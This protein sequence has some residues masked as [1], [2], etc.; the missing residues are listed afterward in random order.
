MLLNKYMVVLKNGTLTI[1][2]ATTKEYNNL[3]KALS[4]SLL[5]RLIPHYRVVGM[6]FKYGAGTSS[7]L[8]TCP[9]FS[10]NLITIGRHAAKYIIPDHM[11]PRDPSKG[12]FEIEGG[13]DNIKNQSEVFADF[14][15]V[16][17]SMDLSGKEVYD[18][19]ICDE[20]VMQSLGFLMSSSAWEINGQ[21]IE[22]PV[23]YSDSPVFIQDNIF[24]PKA[25]LHLIKG[26]EIVEQDTDIMS[27][28]VFF[29]YKSNGA[30]SYSYQ[31]SRDLFV[32]KFSKLIPVKQ[33]WDLSEF[34]TVR[35]YQPGDEFVK[36]VYWEDINEEALCN[37]LGD[38]LDGRTI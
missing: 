29:L 33:N 14:F 26:K 11:I 17:K 16:E 31:K 28:I 9:G 38:F 24:N 13:E 36:L 30:E 20:S 25:P 35:E 2:G 32:Q 37:I 23:I 34:V 27:Q 8:R 6:M 19:R 5:K 21:M 15:N 1:P 3:A 12:C 18:M 4:Y 22:Y 7:M 10:D